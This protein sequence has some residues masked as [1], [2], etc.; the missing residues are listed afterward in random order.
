MCCNSLPRVLLTV[1]QI[2]KTVPWED[3]PGT[4]MPAEYILDILSDVAG[5]LADSDRYSSLDHAGED[6]ELSRRTQLLIEALNA[7]WR[8]WVDKHPAACQEHFPSLESTSTRD[9]EGL[10]FPSLLRFSDV[11]DAHAV[12]L[13]NI[14][15]ILLLHIWINL[16]QQSVPDATFLLDEA[17]DTPLL[18]ISS[19]IKGLAHEIVRA[20]EY[21]HD[22]S[23]RF[24]GTFC[25]IL[26]QDIAYECLDPNSREA[27][28]LFEFEP[29]VSLGL[30]RRPVVG[31]RQRLAWAGP[32]VL[33]EP[34]RK[35]ANTCCL[36]PKVP[37]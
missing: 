12:C 29:A 14:A 32:A 10:L 11:W 17:N 20:Y 28:F 1:A 31:I 9:S 21:C 37:V 13:Y 36:S 8:Y 4:K 33:P 34:W 25:I 7:W 26:P 15:R 5:V 18:G 6:I 3:D 27:R 23:R 35:N 22:D 30:S 2:W 16:P 19:D 24:V